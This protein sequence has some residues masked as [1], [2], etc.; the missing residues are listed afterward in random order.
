MTSPTS[1]THCT[2]PLSCSTTPVTRLMMLLMAQQHESTG[3]SSNSLQYPSQKKLY[4]MGSRTS[5]EGTYT[6]C[7]VLTS[8]IESVIS[9]GSSV[10]SSHTTSSS[11]ISSSISV[12]RTVSRG[13]FLG[14]KS[15]FEWRLPSHQARTE[16]TPAEL[17]IR[18]HSKQ[19]QLCCS[20]V[21]V[22]LQCTP[23]E[24]KSD[25]SFLNFTPEQFAIVDIIPKNLVFSYV[26]LLRSS[27]VQPSLLG[28]RVELGCLDQRF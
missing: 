10:I 1:T 2:R 26:I 11:S 24:L 5:K 18:Y 16:H 3:D 7:A 12:S 15:L 21:A 4:S 28:F 20:G 6:S 25:T 17:S 13:D 14:L 23:L 8:Y 27:E 9:A 19:L 22:K